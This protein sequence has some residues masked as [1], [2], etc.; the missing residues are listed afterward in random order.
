VEGA[1][2]TALNAVS[3]AARRKTVP[4]IVARAFQ[5]MMGLAVIFCL[6]AGAS[7]LNASD[8]KKSPVDPLLPLMLDEVHY[9]LTDPNSAVLF[10]ETHFGARQLAH[11]GALPLK[12]VTMLS[13]QPAEGAIHIS[14][15]GPFEGLTDPDANRWNKQ[16]V[17]PAAT[18]P[19]R[20]GVY[21]VGLRTASLKKAMQKIE[22]RGVTLQE[23][24]L[25]LP[26][27]PTA[28][29]ASIFGPN[30]NV[31]A[32]VEHPKHHGDSGEFGL[33]HV[34]LLVKNVDE[35]VR[36][37]VDV[38]GAA[39]VKRW[40]HGAIL[41]VAGFPIAMSDPAGLDLDPKEVQ[42][43]LPDQFR[44]EADHLSFLYSDIQPA[45]QAAMSKGR[46]FAVP[47]TRM[48]YF[49]KP[50]PYTFAVINSP[51]GLPFELT[52]ED[53]RVGPRDRYVTGK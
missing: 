40:E 18:L 14:P 20:Y 35:N 33:D 47:P 28:K 17:E 52:S 21:W 29:A 37:F 5:C 43:R 25:V 3:K 31:F 16:L 19:P 44:F 10:F 7:F 1:L 6:A 51:D 11:P 50:T 36:F 38:F 46:K 24:N 27:D 49:G 13:L 32:L 48:E 34:Q 22:G 12:F 39:I 53:G 42:E 4:R 8:K 9:Y 2:K 23:R 30:F 15:P 45:V 26:I 41:T